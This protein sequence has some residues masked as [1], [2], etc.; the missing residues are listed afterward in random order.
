MYF[1]ELVRR[2]VVGIGFGVALTAAT[3]FG[4]AS[5]FVTS[6]SAATP[7]NEPVTFCHRSASVSNPY[8]ALTTDADSIISQGHGAHTGPIFPQTG[9]DGFWGDIIPPFSYSGG[10]FPGLNWNSEG[11]AVVNADCEVDETPIEPPVTTTTST[12]TTS[13]TTIPG[14]S[15]TTTIPPVTTP[16]TT[17]PP[18]ERPPEVVNPP[19]GAEITP[20]V[21]AE[22]IDPG[23]KVVDLGP[24]SPQ[25]RV[26]LEEEL[27]QVPSGAPAAGLGGA[28]APNSPST[29]WL[30]A[31]EV[32]AAAA[33][34]A[35][36]VAAWRYRR[37]A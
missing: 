8:V 2:I 20:P 19:D 14:S 16:P 18:T 7:G 27:D 34:I 17:A 25:E 23:D 10:Y 28:S 15:T 30:V 4:F 13:T 32:L 24:L 6:A 37:R 9:P 21:E 36:G 35:G 1:L 22:V 31:G 5:L 29:D 33:V 26:T 11:Q 3:L 12:T